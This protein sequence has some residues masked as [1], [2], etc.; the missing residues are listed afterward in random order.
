MQELSLKST[1]QI[2]FVTEMDLNWTG[3]GGGIIDDLKTLSCLKEL[4]HVNTVYLQKGECRSMLSALGLFIF[5]ILRTFSKPC[6]IYF[7]RGLNTSFIVLSFKSL[8]RKDIKVVHKTPVPFPSNEVRYLKYNK[9]ESFARYC[10]FRFLEKIVM[11]KVDAIMVP[12]SDYAMELV[13]NG[14]D[15]NKVHVI[16]YYIENEFFKQSIKYDVNGAFTFCYVGSFLS[17]HNLSPLVEAFELIS[18][19]DKT[20]RLLLVGDGISRPEMEKMVLDKGLVDRVRFQDR[21]PHSSIPLLLSSEVD[22][23]V[24]FARTKGISTSLLEAAAAGK[25]ILTLKKRQDAALTRYF[26]HGEEIFMISS[27]SPE[28]VAE[29]LRLLRRDSK[30]RNSLC[31][32]AKKTARKYFSR[33]ATIRRLDRLV[34]EVLGHYGN[35]K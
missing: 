35:V 1:K 18:Q 9:I 19:T 8:L 33:K 11:S 7:S 5:K 27:L 34:N 4:G 15:E 30:L 28:K 10:I 22:C 21:V 26:K 25:P 16:P 13:K 12:S 2:C 20:V 6:Q 31:R 3:G 14:V 23:F 29:A 17:Y 32:K 24:Y